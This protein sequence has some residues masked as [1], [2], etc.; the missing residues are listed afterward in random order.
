ML[1]FYNGAERRPRLRRAVRPLSACI[2]VSVLHLLYIYIYICCLRVARKDTS[3]LNLNIVL[4]FIRRLVDV[5]Q[6]FV[7][8]LV[9][10][11]YLSE[12][13]VQV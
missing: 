8:V 12:V 6:L 11:K 5:A 10:Y 2:L 7:D 9:T 3:Q 13:H 1:F 4:N